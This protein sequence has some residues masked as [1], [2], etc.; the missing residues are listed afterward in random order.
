MTR[1]IV[2]E[3][4]L[5]L[6]EEWGGRAEAAALGPLGDGYL[7]RWNLTPDGPVM[8]GMASI[9]QPVRRADGAPARAPALGGRHGRGRG[10]GRRPAAALG[11]ALRERA[12]RRARAVAGHRPEAAGRRP[13]VRRAAGARQP[14]GGGGGHRRPGPGDPAPL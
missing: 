4:F 5:A 14:L 3:A 6:R 10:R 2:P 13:G 8:H 1:V 11:P 7:D 9:V 12:R